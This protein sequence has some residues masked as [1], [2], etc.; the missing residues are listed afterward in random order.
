MA[1]GGSSAADG[2]IVIIFIPALGFPD[3]GLEPRWHV[4]K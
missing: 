3:Q 1:V 4:D 2:R